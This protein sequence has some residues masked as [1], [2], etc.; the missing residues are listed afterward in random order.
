MNGPAGRV[1]VAMTGCGFAGQHVYLPDLISDS[2]CELAGV[3]DTDAPLARGAAERFGVGSW[4]TDTET[5]L[6]KLQP[7]LFVNVTPAAGHAAITRL[8][9][10]LGCHVYSEKPL[11]ASV[12]ESRELLAVAAAAQRY[13]A[14]APDV[15]LRPAVRALREVYGSGAL[16]RPLSITARY[17]GSLPPGGPVRTPWYYLDGGGALTD[18]GSYLMTALIAICG[19]VNR[20]SAFTAVTFA[21]RLTGGTTFRPTAEDTAAVLV[22][23]RSGPVAVV[24]TG[25]HF[26]ADTWRLLFDLSGGLGAVRLAGEDFYH[27]VPQVGGPDGWRDLPVE[28]YGPAE[29][30]VRNTIRCLLE[31]RPPE[32]TAEFAVHT[33]EV[34]EAAR[35]SERSGQHVPVTPPGAL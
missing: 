25:F 32:L 23:F 2:R 16:G 14:A 33:L 1:R 13:L 34:L 12:R 11:A 10:G 31:G 5:M 17:A 6:R 15:A 30:G 21:E 24:Q 7:D 26:A 28:P 8:A 27:C 35:T 22:E 3:C 19:P 4:F 18:M 29:T 9:L 20:V